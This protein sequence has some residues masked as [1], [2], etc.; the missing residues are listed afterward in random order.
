MH[1]IATFVP[2]AALYVPA[3]HNSH[4][5]PSGPIEP[6]AQLTEHLSEEIDPG[7]D[8]SPCGQAEQFAD[9]VVFFHVPDTHLTQG[10]SPL[11]PVYPALQLHICLV[12][13]ADGE[14]DEAGQDRQTAGQRGERA[15][16]QISVPQTRKC[17]SC[18]VYD[19]N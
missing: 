9:P 5:P 4:G 10:P 6:G 7:R 18:C 11:G 19:S 13:L 8:V 14:V 1:F 3:G 17:V 2:D 12:A 16:C 15:E